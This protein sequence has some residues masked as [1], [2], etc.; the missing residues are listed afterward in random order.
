M[1]RIWHHG[2]TSR[3]VTMTLMNISRSTFIIVLKRPGITVCPE[4][5]CISNFV[6]FTN[7]SVCRQSPCLVLILT[8][9]N[10]S[11]PAVD[12]EY[13]NIIITQS[14]L[15]PFFESNNVIIFPFGRSIGSNWRKPISN[16][17]CMWCE[18]LMIKR[19]LV[20]VLCLRR[21][22]WPGLDPYVMPVSVN[23][24]DPHHASLAS[25][26]IT[27]GATK[28]TWCWLI[29]S[30][31]CYDLPHNGCSAYV[32]RDVA[33]YPQARCRR[34]IVAFPNIAVDSSDKEVSGLAEAQLGI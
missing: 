19:S 8:T 1:E 29:A 27:P 30:S 11:S 34:A 5:N 16:V 31:S 23:Q 26:Y 2:A 6:E 28:V 15:K 24:T 32:K 3:D 14:R 17:V 25:L 7:R 18:G 21:N 20:H 10:C 33:W 12:T 22:C 13:N 4:P 9:K